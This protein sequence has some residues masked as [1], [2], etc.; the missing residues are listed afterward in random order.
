MS[1][2]NTFQRYEIK[3]MISKAQKERILSVIAPY[4][5]IDKY[6]RTIIRNLYF[7]TDSYRLI[8]R[9]N[10]KPI[11]KEKLRIRSYALA[12]PDSDVFVELK[13]K[14]KSVVYKRRL[15]LPE[16]AVMEAFSDGTP[17]PVS[18]QI[19]DEIAY[20]REFYGPLTPKVY[21]SYAREAFYMLDGSDFRI[22]FDDEIQ[23][24]T[25]DL[26]L[27]KEPS[28]TPL[29]KDGLVLMEVKAPG[30]LPLWLIKAL[31]EERIFKT[32]FSK[33][34]TAYADILKTKVKGDAY[35]D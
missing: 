6:G 31:T 28:G 5:S 9:S 23:Y 15:T 10:E 8:R 25:S 24:R 19:G 16:H 4:M 12:T 21:L 7:D 33:Y 11:Y 27:T 22:T 13:K 20:F 2:Q 34:G 35:H 18:S 1:H 32:T 14:Y 30:A 17:L 3:Y 29:L 26:T